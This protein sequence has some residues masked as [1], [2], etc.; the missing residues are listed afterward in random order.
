MDRI[1]TDRI[2][3]DRI[4]MNGIIKDKIITGIN[5]K[6][7]SYYLLRYPRFICNASVGH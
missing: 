3:T 1:I 7:F 6:I 5:Y 2:I 4:I